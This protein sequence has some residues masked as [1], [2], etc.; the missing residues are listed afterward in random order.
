M[1]VRLG[2]GA[3]VVATLAAAWG[4]TAVVAQDKGGDA[5]KP[6]ARKELRAGDEI[7][8]VVT[9]RAKVAADGTIRVP[10]FGNVDA[11]GRTIDELRAVMTKQAAAPGVTCAVRAATRAVSVIGAIQGS[12]E[13]P[14]GRST[15]ILEVLASA[16]A[17]DHA[18]NGDFSRVSVR[19]TDAAGQPFTFSVNVDDIIERNQEQQNVVVFENDVVVVP[20]AQRSDAPSSGWTYVLGQVHSP[21]RYPILTGRTPF[22]LTKLMAL[23]GDFGGSAD[24]AHVRIVRLGSTGRE[25]FDVD[26]DA[27][28]EGKVQD[29]EL[30][31]DDVVYVGARK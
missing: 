16:G 31:P 26:F 23:C 22:T 24:R 30:R 13:L 15:R 11:A 7:D 1:N 5:A 29:F 27:I 17:F 18:A 14:A 20:K 3:V 12:V 2:W 10:G 19:R 21:G 6:A 8:V 25:E 28:V 9:C 4:A